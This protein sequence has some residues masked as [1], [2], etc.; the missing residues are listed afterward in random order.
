MRPAEYKRKLDEI[1]HLLNDPDAPLD[2]ARVW[3]L[4]A[5]I[6]QYDV[7]VDTCRAYGNSGSD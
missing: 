6:A 3:C 1:D 7:V 5:E 2:A 4:L